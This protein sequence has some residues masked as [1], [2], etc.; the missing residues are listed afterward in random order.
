MTRCRLAH[1]KAFT[2]VELLVVIA[3]IGI[4]IALLLPAV[5]AAREAARRI[6]CSNNMKQVGIGL[7]NYHSSYEQFPGG[8]YHSY[9]DTTYGAKPPSQSSMAHSW[10]WAPRI[11]PFLENRTWA[12]A[13][14]LSKT[15]YETPNRE[16]VKNRIPAFECPSNPNLDKLVRNTGN[17]SYIDQISQ[18]SYAATATYRGFTRSNAVISRALTHTGEGVI[19]GFSGVHRIS[20]RDITDGT[21]HTFIVAEVDGFSPLSSGGYSGTTWINNTTSTLYYGLNNQKYRS[22]NQYS[23]IASYH[24][25]IVNFLYC[26]GHVASASEGADTHTL[27]GELT[28]TDSLN[29]RNPAVFR[30]GV[31]LYG[32]ELAELE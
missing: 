22:N 18:T 5:Q 20:I 21:S 23:A 29:R 32:N 7:L 24:P 26:D 6:S 8:R 3:I 1:P 14:D 16:V 15:W 19:F 2:L 13:F 25:G 4:L 12:D 30:D 27:I 17:L 31:E 11:L 10:G 9:D 28:R